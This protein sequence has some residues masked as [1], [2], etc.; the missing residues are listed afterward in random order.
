MSI[1]GQALTWD[2]SYQD[3]IVLWG[4]FCHLFETQDSGRAV[5][6]I[7][8][9]FRSGVLFYLI[10]TC[11]GRP[12]GECRWVEPFNYQPYREKCL[13]GHYWK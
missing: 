4:G 1:R 3:F 13:A 2:N 7:Y 11:F 6:M 10:C 9:R 5:F 12:E 8:Y